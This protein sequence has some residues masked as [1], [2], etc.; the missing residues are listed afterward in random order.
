MS[1]EL[2]QRANIDQIEA[3]RNQ[4]LRLY[5]VA[6]DAMQDAR[7]AQQWGDTP[8]IAF[9]THSAAEPFRG[10]ARDK[11]L[12]RTRQEVDRG[13]WRYL[14]DA[15]KLESLMDHKARE[16][17][18][19]QLMKDPPEATAANCRATMEQFAGDADMIFK[20]GVA[21]CFSNLD[22]RFRSHDGFKIGSR[23]VLAYAFDGFGSFVASARE[24]L[25]DV[26]RAIYV[27]DGKQRPDHYNAGI[28]GLIS[29]ET[30]GLQNG[31]AHVWFLRDDL[32]ERVNLLL[33]E[34]YGEALGA[35]ADAAEPEHVRSTAVARN[36]GFFPTPRAV[37]N[38]VLEKAG[39]GSPEW[40]GDYPRLSI[41][42]PSAGVGDMAGVAAEF[43]HRVTC[44]EL[45][46]GRA[47]ELRMSGKYA[48][49]VRGDFLQMLDSPAYDRVIMNPP[50]DRGLDMDHVRHAFRFLKPGGTLCAVMSAATAYR[51][52][53]RTEA[54]RAWADRYKADSL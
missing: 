29:A 8:H 10:D 35:G 53:A 7:K 5:E 34:Y 6:F 27:L 36:M 12:Q 3:S 28:A 4:A 14:I 21:E 46:E 37:V 16:Q 26:E 39:V 49:V 24:K 44:V 15:T 42:E 17:F 41:L 13:V 52:D 2:I 33:A 32:L 54:F 50:F 31:N 22:R 51:E 38:R 47:L 11:F 20:R 25:I 43:G 45:H 40:R 48:N 23:M 18:R 9:G 30:R 1:G 19:D